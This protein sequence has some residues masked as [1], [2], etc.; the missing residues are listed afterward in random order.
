MDAP[1]DPFG[2]LLGS[3]DPSR[4]D[5]PP[6]RG[7]SRYHSILETAMSTHAPNA[8]ST[9]PAPNDDGSV[10]LDHGRSDARRPGPGRWV[11]GAA[12]A[13]LVL[14]A[15]GGAI[16][17]RSNDDTTP[18]DTTTSAAPTTVP[19]EVHSLRGE[20][21]IVARDG[22]GTTRSTLRVT[23]NDREAIS[24][25]EFPDGTTESSTRTLIGNT[26]YETVDGVTTRRSVTA[27]DPTP[28]SMSSAMV[29][30]AMTG[31]SVRVDERRVDWEGGTATRLDL[32]PTPQL[33]PALSALSAGVLAWFELEY[34]AEVE[35]V[36]LWV[37][38]QVVHQI[39]V[40]TAQVVTRS[41]FSD[42]NG[43]IA[44]TPPPGPYDDATG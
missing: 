24:T 41:T 2:A 29:V 18:A 22:S 19:D 3:I 11:L 21:T 28:F 16:A 32:Q 7:S 33:A 38:G 9:E 39:E 4:S 6:A 27:E 10:P 13:L 25:R 23:G 15:F 36:T 37:T 26:E 42:F 12:A 17:L 1:D 40:T 44:I 34:P 20:V 35:S 14:A 8:D 31:N 43:D 5:G 30:K